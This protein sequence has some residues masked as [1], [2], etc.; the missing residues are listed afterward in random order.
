MNLYTQ[1]RDAAE[2]AAGYAHRHSKAGNHDFASLMSRFATKLHELASEAKHLPD[3]A[4]GGPDRPERPGMSIGSV[5]GTDWTDD[6]IANGRRHIVV[7]GQKEVVEYALHAVLEGQVEYVRADIANGL[8]EML[9]ASNE[10]IP[11]DTELHEANAA[12]IAKAESTA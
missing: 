7:A 10:W 8:L 1:I 5:P 11:D 4:R 12:V 3:A 6:I 2:S 9:K